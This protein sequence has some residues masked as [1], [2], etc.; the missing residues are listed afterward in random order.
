MFFHDKRL[1]YHAEPERPDPLFA[2][3]LQEFSAGSGA[4]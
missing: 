4:R 3:Q 1:R 2:K